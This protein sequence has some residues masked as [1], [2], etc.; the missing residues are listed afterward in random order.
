MYVT[1]EEAIGFINSSSNKIKVI[2]FAIENCQYCDDFLP[3]VFDVQM[4][5]MSE[6]FE[7]RYL[8]VRNQDIPFPP[9]YAPT[10]YFF[11]PGT[12][13]PM[14]LL[15]SG[16]TLPEL[17]RKDLEAMIAIKDQGLTIEQAYSG[18]EIPQ[19]TMWM[20]RLIRF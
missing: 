14:P 11:I 15:R 4:S 3:D 9:H 7:V 18:V 16:G 6:H 12:Q 5:E 10:F 2:T 20:Q 19:P 17:L 1:Y 13:E 8:D